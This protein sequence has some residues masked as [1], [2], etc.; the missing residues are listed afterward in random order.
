MD[1]EFSEEQ[2]AL[3][4]TV[5]RFLAE[6][7]PIQPY[8]RD[9]Y[10]DVRGTTDAVWKGLAELGATGLLI[11]EAHGGAGMGMVDIGVVLEEL[12]RA[13]HPGPFLS[14]AV[15][16]VSALT[17]TGGADDL[18][19]LIA[20]GSLVATIALVENDG[21]DWRRVATTAAGGTVS[22]Q[23]AFVPDAVAADMLLV[24]ARDGRDL[25]LFA[26]ESGAPGLEVTPLASVDGSRSWATVTFDK[27]PARPLC[28]GDA[29]Q[30]VAEVVDRLLVAYATDGL[31][32]AEAALE[33]AVAYAKERVQFDRPIGSS[34]AVQHLCADMLQALELG[35]AGAYYALWACDAAPPGERHRAAVMA[36]AFASDAFPRIGASA[37]QVFGGVGFTWEHDIH[38]FYKRLLTLQEAYGDASDA[39]EELAGL[40]L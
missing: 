25:G 11:P 22:G 5:R 3:R 38:L 21:R 31:G 27:T 35:R 6:Q 8:V 40:V 29:T 33:L 10:G 34:Q 15:A 9:L 23:K 32:A 30:A 37:I 17:A 20:D 7:A 39:L 16:A 4:A 13:I 14:S 2:E 12:G 28:D 18:L 1:F 36:K 26:V 19:P 24:T